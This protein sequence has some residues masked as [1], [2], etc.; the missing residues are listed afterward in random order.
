MS[1]Y[2]KYPDIDVRLTGED[3]N[4]FSVISRVVKALKD[5]GVSREEVEE[6]QT[7]AMS[8][9]YNNLLQTCMRWVNVS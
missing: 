7:E 3:S 8:G 6:F 4:A 9:D 2:T 1:A 5:A